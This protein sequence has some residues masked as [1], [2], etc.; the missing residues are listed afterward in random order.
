MKMFFAIVFLVWL[1]VNTYIFIRGWQVIPSAFIPRVIYTVLFVC[2]SFSFFVSMGFRDTMPLTPLKMIYAISTVWLVCMM[3]YTL[4]F[5]VT[6]LFGLLNHWLHILPDNVTAHY[7]QIQVYGSTIIVVFLLFYG[8]HKFTHPSVEKYDIRIDKGAGEKKELRVVGISDVHL[9]L[10]VDKSRISGYIDKINAQKPDVIFIAGDVV[11]NSTRILNEEHL[12]EE[13]NRLNA[14]LG[15]YMCLGN[16]EYISGIK[17]SLDFLKKTKIQLLVDSAACVDDS[18][19]V[20][21]RD[22][23]TNHD[24]KPLNKMLGYTDKTKPL[25]LL[26][27]QPNDLEDARMN[28]IDL[29]FS[30]HTHNG[31]L[32]PGNLIVKKIFEVGYGYKQKDN[33]H[34][35]VSS[36]L[37][38][39]GP[40]V[41]IGTQS[42]MVVFDIKFD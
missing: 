29:Q 36:G 2:I 34:V 12:E 16:H 25:F 31:Q 18:F 14:P 37:T 10:L 13:L 21:G 9:G 26:D 17:N 11:D 23:R 24:R 32:W 20:I 5:L 15:I 28:G 38:L 33:L 27:H 39:W 35:Y 42:E 8:Y 1:L 19:Y 30:G 41:R 40:L 3:Y 4:L 6:D 22:D 7:R